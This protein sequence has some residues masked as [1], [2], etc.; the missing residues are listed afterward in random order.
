MMDTELLTA[1]EMCER[2]KTNFDTFRRTWKRWKHERVGVGNTLRSMRFYWQSGP[3]RAE[4]N[5]GGIEVSDKERTALDCRRVS[6]RNTHLK[7]GGVSDK[8]RRTG[9]GRGAENLSDA[10]RR[11]GL[12]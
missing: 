11:F 9:V 8:A 2:L 5:D 3:V 6:G 4:A 10:A 1:D 12:A 7:E